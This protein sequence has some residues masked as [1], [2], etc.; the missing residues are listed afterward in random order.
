MQAR[1][2]LLAAFASVMVVAAPATAQAQERGSRDEAKAMT[3]A[4]VEHVKKVGPDKAFKD[5]T[6]DPA[7]KKKD[8]YVMAYDS[9]GNV[10]GHGANEKLIGKNLMEM[11]DPNGVYVVAELTK[12]AVSKG[13]GWVDY[14]WPHPQ[15]KKLEDKSTYVHRLQ[16][17]DGWVGVGIYR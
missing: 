15:T 13:E 2:F 11:R 3:I 5:F 6:S 16:N 8:L 7:W 14:A 12:M 9:K 10:V 1:R 17:F 4:A